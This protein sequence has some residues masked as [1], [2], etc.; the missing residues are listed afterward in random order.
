MGE[1]VKK[2]EITETVNKLYA[3]RAG[4]SLVDNE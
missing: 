2:G 3:L 4:L 1:L